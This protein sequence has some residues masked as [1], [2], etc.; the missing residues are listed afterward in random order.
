MLNKLRNI[1]FFWRSSD[2]Q[3]EAHKMLPANVFGEILTRLETLRNEQRS[4]PVKR[5][6]SVYISSNVACIGLLIRELE[7]IA[8]AMGDKSPINKYYRMPENWPGG[9]QR[10]FL[11]DFLTDCNGMYQDYEY[12]LRSFDPP[13]Q[14]ILLTYDMEY[15]EDF[16]DYY[17]SKP[18]RLYQDIINV[19]DQLIALN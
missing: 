8:L 3:N 13:L 2:Q 10:I 7:N 16:R 14:R 15:N 12:F 1:L 9:V 5:R 18:H 6:Q 4:F 11:D 17:V 19:L